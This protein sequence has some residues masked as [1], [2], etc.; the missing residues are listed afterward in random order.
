MARGSAAA[1]ASTSRNLINNRSLV[2][3]EGLTQ[4]PLSCPVIR[5]PRPLNASWCRA[6]AGVKICRSLGH[7]LDEGFGHPLVESVVVILATAA[8]PECRQ[9]GPGL[10]PSDRAVEARAGRFG[11]DLHL[12]TELIS[13]R[14]PLL[15]PGPPVADGG[16]TFDGHLPGQGEGINREPRTAL[17]RQDV[18]TVQVATE[19]V[20]RLIGSQLP[21]GA[22]AAAR[23]WG[24]AG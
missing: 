8:D 22:T 21:T 18:P 2:D 3:V 24:G 13:R 4:P 15:E 20:V 12:A 14:R 23:T 17:A 5:D 9:Q 10:G 7:L 1:N 11:E 16:Q 6:S 19:Q